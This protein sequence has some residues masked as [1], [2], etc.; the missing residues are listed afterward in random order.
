MHCAF[1]DA[2]KA[3]DKVL[4]NG[5]F[6][7]LLKRGAPVVFVRLLQKWYSSLRCVKWNNAMGELFPV[8]CGVRQGGVLSPYL[9]TVYIDDLIVQLRQTGY[10]IHVGQIFVGCALYADDIA[11]LSASCYGLQN[12]LMSALTTEQFGI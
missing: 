1:L 12:L 8:L 7:K 10:G 11:L 2:S 4:H 3:F 9:F 6:L 5:L